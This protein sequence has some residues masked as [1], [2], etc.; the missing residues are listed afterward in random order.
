MTPATCLPEAG[1]GDRGAGHG[2]VGSPPKLL[3]LPDEPAGV[4]GNED[5][6]NG[7]HG[8]GGEREKLVDLMRPPLT[9][10]RASPVSRQVVPLRS[11]AVPGRIALRSGIT[12]RAARRES[13]LKSGI[14]VR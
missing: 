12:F 8:A 6:G 3:H 1:R 2:R 11:E 10:G 5:A 7:K 13:R 14:G 9:T 4:D